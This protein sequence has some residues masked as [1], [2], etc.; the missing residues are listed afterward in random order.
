MRVTI[1]SAPVGAG[2]DIA[3]RRVASELEARGATVEVVDGLELIGSRIERLVIDGYRFQLSRAA[4]S[5]R[6]TYAYSRSPLVMRAV[7][8]VLGRLGQ[9]R[10]EGHLAAAGPDLVVSTYPLVSAALASLRR[11]GR[12][13]MP[14]VTLITD[15]DAHPAWVHSDLD[16]N[17][18]VA[19][20]SAG[21]LGVR[22]PVE[23]CREASP[24]GVRDRLGLAEGERLVLIVGG[25]WGVG[26]LHEAATA[27]EQVA[28][29][30]AIV[31]TGHNEEL[32]ARMCGDPR[33]TR[34]I[35][36]GFR[37]DLLDLIAASDVIIQHA[38]G[39]TCLEAFALRVPVVMFHP[40]LGHGVSNAACMA[41]AGVAITAGDGPELGRLLADP[42]FWGE[43]APA[44]VTE[45]AGLLAQPTL[46]DRVDALNP[47]ATVMRR[48]RQVARLALGAAVSLAVLVAVEDKADAAV[49]A[50]RLLLP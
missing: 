34:S 17:L 21:V 48:P 25:T 9:R 35:V 26:S 6:V 33:L 5:W 42:A 20:S 14:I 45:A 7:G 19:G 3:A 4:W 49:H 50:I 23:A 38:G 43:T 44:M 1:L 32:R 11:R 36:F 27:V 2:H 8:G 46:G 12:V 13:A 16:A 18:S 22:P 15:F 28:G 29:V 30:R 24:E 40:V 10:L 47:L 39:M 31:V 37:D 41:Q